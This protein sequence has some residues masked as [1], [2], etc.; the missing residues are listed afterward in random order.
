MREAAPGRSPWP[1]GSPVSSP[2]PAAAS[3]AASPAALAARGRRRGAGRAAQRRRR[4]QDASPARCDDAGGTAVAITAD[5]TDAGA[6]GGGWPREVTRRLGAADDPRQ[7]GRAP[8]APSTSC[9][10]VDPDAWVAHADGQRRR[11]VP[12][13]AR[14]PAR[15]CSAQGWGRIVNVTSAA[16]LHPPGPLN[17]A[18][19]TSKV[20]LNQFTRHLAAELAGTGVTANVF[21]PGDVKT[22]IWADI[23]DQVAALGSDGRRLR[24]AGSTWVE[25]TGGDPPEKAADAR[26]CGSSPTTRRRSTASS[27]GSR[28]ACSR[29]SRAGSSRATSGPGSAHVRVVRP[30][31]RTP[32]GRDRVGSRECGGEG[33]SGS[34]PRVRPCSRRRERRRLRQCC[35][36]QQEARTAGPAREPR[37]LRELRPRLPRGPGR[38]RWSS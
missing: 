6:G 10:D 22:E 1:A 32:P 15:A 37:P 31:R 26:R 4:W 24:A 28:T 2:A 18:Y 8:S 29:P 34:W 12:Y 21:H 3:G 7:R 38:D 9:W 20:A 17:S 19:G 11:A 23:R 33:W 25:E 36:S 35:T 13:R 14:L 5:V 27:C 16:A 30:R